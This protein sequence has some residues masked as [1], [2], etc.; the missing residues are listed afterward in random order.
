MFG[1]LEHLSHEDRLRE[2]VLLKLEKRLLRGD[3]I[4]YLKGT[5]IP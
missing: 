4:K 2:L 1:R 3:L 5:Q